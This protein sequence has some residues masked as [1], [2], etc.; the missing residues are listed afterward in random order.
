M[1]LSKKAGGVVVAGVLA[2]T[3]ALS[4]SGATAQGA[5][6]RADLRPVPHAASADAG[7]NVTG[8]AIVSRVASRVSVRL[9][10]RG[11]TPGL[12]HAM[13]IHGELKARNECPPAR[14]DVNDQVSSTDPGTPDGLVSLG[15]GFPFYG[16]VQVSFTTSGDTSDA[17]AL[18]LDRFPVAQAD[19]DLSYERR[20]MV[21]HKIAAKTGKLHVVVHGVDLDGDGAYS[22]LQEAT[23]PVAC[24][25][26][27]H[28]P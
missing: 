28:T 3:A 4:A 10:A 6:Y 25:E 11:L 12:P 15:E 7:S 27:N 17:S 2:A 16:P 8:T 21:P 19:G 1:K 5:R 18:A 13:H 23:L 24:G 20:I 14:A 26:L 9:N 22:N